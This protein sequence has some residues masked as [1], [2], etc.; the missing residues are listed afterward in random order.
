M[1]KTKFNV[2]EDYQMHSSSSMDGAGSLQGWHAGW[3]M[4]MSRYRK[5][6]HSD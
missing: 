5:L 4:T 3:M 6:L 2:L 1:E